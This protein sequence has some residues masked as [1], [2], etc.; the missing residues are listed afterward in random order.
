[1]NTPRYFDHRG[2]EVTRE[3]IQHA[4]EAGTATLVHGRG[5]GKTVTALAF[6]EIIDTRGACYSM[7]EEIW[8]TQPA[9]LDECLDVA[10]E[11]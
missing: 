10:R 11:R 4:F 1:M 8:F 7:W 6:E 3:Q 9:T 2:N 5:E